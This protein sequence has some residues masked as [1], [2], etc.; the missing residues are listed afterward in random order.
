MPTTKNGQKELRTVLDDGGEVYETLLAWAKKRRLTPGK[1]IGCILA[2]WSDAIAGRPNPFAI[3]I[4]AA[5][6]VNIQ[7]GPVPPL[8]MT[9]EEPEVSPEEKARQAALLEAAEQF[10]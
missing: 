7:A 3:A 2:D 6:G 5:S 1:A 8:Q 9:A 4:A 10:M